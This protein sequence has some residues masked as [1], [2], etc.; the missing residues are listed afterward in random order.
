[1][2][3]P[4][5]AELM[6][7]SNFS[8]LRS[9]SHPEELVAAAMALGLGGIGLADRNTFAGV[10]RGYVAH[11][12]MREQ[13]PGF[14]YVVGVR[15]VFA[16]GAPDILA[17]PSDREAYGRLCRLLSRANLREESEKG[18]PVVLFDDLEEFAEGQLFV[19]H[20][21][22]SRWDIS[23]DYLKQ[24]A[25]MAP[26]N[27]WLPAAPTFKGSDRAR[28]NRLAHTAAVTGVPLLASQRARSTTS[29]ARRQRAGRTSAASAST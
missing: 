28:L 8:F 29:P 25:A 10:V 2:S 14:R 7:S 23:V 17:Y 3:R 13:H 27:V 19:F 1:M 6:A 21:D 22:E 15:L 4:A 24:L 9:G 11:R 20:L 5:Y 16:D 26:G 12:D 18:N